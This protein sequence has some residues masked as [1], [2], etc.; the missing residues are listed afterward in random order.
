MTSPANSTVVELLS[1]EDLRYKKN[2]S[3]SKHNE[4]NVGKADRDY[5]I[6]LKTTA[7][8]F[9]SLWFLTKELDFL[10][11]FAFTYYFKTTHLWHLFINWNK[12]FEEAVFWLQT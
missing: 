7:A 8:F 11:L 12:I 4:K 5:E 1:W 3:L 6:L 2:P 9:I 10:R